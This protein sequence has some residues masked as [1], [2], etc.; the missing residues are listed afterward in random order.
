[1]FTS[2]NNDEFHILSPPGIYDYE[3]RLFCACFS[4][5]QAGKP[6]P[7][8]YISFLPVGHYKY[9]E[10]PLTWNEARKTCSL[11]G[12]HLAVLN[13]EAEARLLASIIPGDKIAWIGVHDFFQDGE[14]MTIFDQTTGSAGFNKWVPNEP[15][16]GT[17]ENCGVITKSDGKMGSYFCPKELTFICE[18]D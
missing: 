6:I 17:N 7:S 14:W 2:C 8:G 18:L 16:G 4:R 5:P 3:G 13:S 10:V 11:E 9:H 15:N 12:S 1:M